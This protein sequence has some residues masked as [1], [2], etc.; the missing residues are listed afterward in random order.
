MPMSKPL[1][2]SRMSQALRMRSSPDPAAVPCVDF[3]VTLPDRGAGLQPA[4]VLPVVAVAL[5]LPLGCERQRAAEH[6]VVVH[7]DEAAR[8]DPD[9]RER[10]AV[11]ADVAADDLRVPAEGA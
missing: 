7:E 9:N 10:L 11:E 5:R 1:G 3:G 2:R 8:H 4:D 6:D